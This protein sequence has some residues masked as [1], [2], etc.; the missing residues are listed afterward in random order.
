MVLL[1]FL[2]GTK[3]LSPW[4]VSSS[5]CLTEPLLKVLEIFIS[6]K[7]VVYPVH[8]T[9]SHL[10]SL[11]FTPISFFSSHFFLFSLCGS[12]IRLANNNVVSRGFLWA[13]GVCSVLI[14]AASSCPFSTVFHI[15]VRTFI[16]QARYEKRKDGLRLIKRHRTQFSFS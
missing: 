8:T 16:W 1:S 15:K 2:W 6:H 10:Y 11:I 12:V 3:S 4:W 5:Y 13:T 9:S 7:T 14:C